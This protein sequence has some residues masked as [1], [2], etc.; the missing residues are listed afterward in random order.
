VKRA[1][2]VVTVNLL[3]FLALVL[4]AEGAARLF[5]GDDLEAI[6]PDRQIQDMEVPFVISHP[7]RGLALAPGY[8]NG[9]YRVGLDG[10]RGSEPAG[11]GPSI[12]A[13]GDST[14]FGWGVAEDETYPAQ[15]A[16]ILHAAGRDVRVINA[17]V[18]GYTSSQVRIALEE[19]V[20]GGMRPERVLISVLWNDLW[21]SSLESWTPDVL[22]SRRP[23]GLKVRLAKHSALF[24]CAMLWNV[25]SYQVDVF[26]EPAYETYLAN[27]EAMLELGRRQG[28][29]IVLIEPPYCADRMP[30]QGLN[31]FQVRYSREFL[32]ELLQRHVAAVRVLARAFGVEVVDH[33]LALGHE[34]PGEL[35]LDPLHPTGAGYRLIAEDVATA[36]EPKLQ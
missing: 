36:L 33:R 13:L 4:A 7:T 12:L 32:I 25:S 28:L 17:G 27:V 6:F 35:F 11:D 22:V 3:G 20:A 29:R 23:S 14:T 34:V 21:Y 19:L 30:Y 24:R 2:S 15:L 10:F 18:P 8:D 31:H 16:E 9:V 1:L 5:L 26:N